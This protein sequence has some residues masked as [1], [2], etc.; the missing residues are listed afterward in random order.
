MIIGV[1]IISSRYNSNQSPQENDNGTIADERLTRELDNDIA[2]AERFGLETYNTKDVVDELIFIEENI[3][4]LTE[5]TDKRI[6]ITGSTAGLGQLTAKYL[7]ERGYSVV[8]HARNEARAED[9]KRDLPDAEAVVIGDL[10]DLDQTIKLASDM[11]QLGSF[12]VIIHNAGVYGVSSE[13][14]LNVNSLSPYILTSLIHKPKQLIYITSD[15]HRGGELKLE[16]MQRESPDITYNDSKLQILTFAM[17]VARKWPDVQVNAAR[18]GWVPTRMGTH[19]GPY[20][21]D[22]L[23]EGYMTQVWLAEGLEEDSQVT[24]AFFFHK[25]PERN[26]NP[27]IHDIELQEALISAYENTT[28]ILFPDN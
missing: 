17:A 25:E 10:S 11:N 15:L 21:P 13:E 9:A 2:A 5:N 16:N 22:S 23:R 27:D 24:G 4:P 28:G 26:Y 6:L 1:L 8:V 3:L 20:A 7:L 19:N 14:I 18:P 12:D